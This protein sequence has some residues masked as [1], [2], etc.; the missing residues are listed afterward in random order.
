MSRELSKLRMEMRA[1]FELTWGAWSDVN[2]RV[3]DM[4]SGMTDMAS[5]M[6]DMSSGMTDM[7]SSMAEMSRAMAHMSSRMAEIS[8]KID[9]TSRLAKEA[10]ASGEIGVARLRQ[11]ERRFSSVLEA[12]EKETSDK[13]SS[14][15]FED[16]EERVRR[17]EEKSDPAA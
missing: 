9:Q 13:V 10:V 4:S 3:D 14:K 8:S 6:T 7:S 5:G 12:V 1:E 15:R 17:L 2:S 11:M 16:L